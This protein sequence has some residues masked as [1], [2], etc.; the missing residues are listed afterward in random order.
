M[1]FLQPL[2]ILLEAVIA[3]LFV[4]AAAKGKT[5]LSGLAI[6]F[7]IYV[8]YDLSKHYAW[9]VSGDLVT[10]LFF[11]ATLTALWSAWK[12]YSRR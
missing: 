7:G 10:V 8:F 12:I 9:N 2:S 6:T 11:I 3:V 1:S 5:Y 4:M